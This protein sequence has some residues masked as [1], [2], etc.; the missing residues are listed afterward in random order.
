MGMVLAVGT[1]RRHLVQIFRYEGMAYNLG[2]A[3]VGCALGIG[4]SLIMVQVMA[5]IFSSFDLSIA[6]LISARSLIVS[7][8]LGVVL[9]YLTVTFSSWRIGNLNIV[10]AIRDT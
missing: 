1:K 4:V 10:S 3:A 2:A 7:Y 8:S 5:A 6:F 9:T